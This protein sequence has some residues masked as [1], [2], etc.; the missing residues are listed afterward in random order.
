[1]LPDISSGGF[2][3][4]TNACQYAI[5]VLRLIVIIL[6]SFDAWKKVFKVK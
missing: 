2:F 3:V 6:M 5:R 4:S 1:M